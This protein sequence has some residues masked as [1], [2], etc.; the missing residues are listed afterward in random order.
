MNLDT[1]NRIMFLIDGLIQCHFPES[2]ESD[3]HTELNNLIS[4]PKWSDDIFWSNE[5]VSENGIV[6]YDKFFDKITQYEKSEIYQK[7]QYVIKL[8]K[9]LINKNFDEKD[10]YQIVAELNSIIQNT[11]WLNWLFVDKECLQENGTLNE[12]YFI[13]KAFY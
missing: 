2:L 8:V 3:I 5:Y 7:H 10:E 1:K 4:Y 6:D 11:E 12:K 9:D 13:I